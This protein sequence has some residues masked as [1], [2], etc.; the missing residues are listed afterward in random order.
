MTLSR[1][2]TAWP[3]A[4]LAAIAM[5]FA[6]GAPAQASPKAAPAAKK[7]KKKGKKGAASAKKKCGKKKKKPVAPGPPQQMLPQPPPPPPPTTE[8]AELTWDDEADLDLYVWDS[9]LRGGYSAGYFEEGSPIPSSQFPTDDLDG[10]GPESFLDAL[11]PSTRE[12]AFGVCV[13]EPASEEDLESEYTITFRTGSGAEV[14]DTDTLT[15]FGD[16]ALYVPPG[17]TDPDPENEF[18]WCDGGEPPEPRR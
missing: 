2:I 9:A 16:A 4:L 13:A 3:L 1:R 12:F 17:A 18:D 14:S 5:V 8:R 10:F 7:C 15:D 6:T 11:S